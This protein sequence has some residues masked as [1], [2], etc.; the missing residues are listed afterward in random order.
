MTT[1]QQS[2]GLAH[3]VDSISGE[4]R[5]P[6]Y[7]RLR[8]SLTEAVSDLFPWE[9]RATDGGMSLWVGAPAGLDA[10]DL[11]TRALSEGVVIERGD[12]CFSEAPRPVNYFQVG[13][14]AMDLESVRPGIERLA[15]LL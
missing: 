7:S 2:V 12:V 3:L 6:R 10:A 1:R 14:A 4:E 9:V 8:D 15:S 11:A 13:F 5:G